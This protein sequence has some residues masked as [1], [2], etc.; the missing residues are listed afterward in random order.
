[1]KVSSGRCFLLAK[2]ETLNTVSIPI[3]KPATYAF[4]SNTSLRYWLTISA[5]T[6]YILLKI[7]YGREFQVFIIN[8]STALFLGLGHF[9]SLLILYTVCRTPWTGDLPVGRPLPKHSSTQAEFEPKAPAFERT[10][11]VHALPLRSA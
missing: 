3:P 7:K 4:H 11:T 5:T 9:S 8:R 10:K 2:P 6:V 1:M